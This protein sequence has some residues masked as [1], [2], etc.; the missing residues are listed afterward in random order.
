VAVTV[1]N[2]VV[3]AEYLHWHWKANMNTATFF[4][5]EIS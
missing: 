3:K 1:G 2:E 4:L 5:L